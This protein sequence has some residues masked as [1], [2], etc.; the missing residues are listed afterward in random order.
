MVFP[1]LLRPGGLGGTRRK[2]RL[3]FRLATMNPARFR[4]RRRGAFPPPHPRRNQC[5]MIPSEPPRPPGP[6]F[7]RSLPH[8][9]FQRAKVL[10][11]LL[12]MLKI[13]CLILISKATFRGDYPHFSLDRGKIGCPQNTCPP[14]GHEIASSASGGFAM[15]IYSMS[16]YLSRSL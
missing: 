13:S 8:T 15:A 3:G 14:D 16:T 9:S 11:F 1:P 4:R 12:Y 2:H 7:P 5:L 10:R 6:G